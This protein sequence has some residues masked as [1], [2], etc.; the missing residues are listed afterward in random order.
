MPLERIQKLE[1]A[2]A[3][4]GKI[5]I[6]NQYTAGIAGEKFLRT[7][8][9]K[10]MLLAARCPE[11]EIVY[12]PAPLYCE[13]C[14]RPLQEEKELAPRGELLTF[15]I[16]HRD[17]DGQ[18]LAE[19]Q[20]LGFIKIAGSDGGLLHYLGEIKAEEIKIGMA[21]QAVLLPKEERQGS[22]L[23]IRY[24]RPIPNQTRD[25]GSA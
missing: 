17:L 4:Q 24:F 15:T 18:S 9:D 11:D 8:Q 12:L 2:R 3:W 13:R 5:P 10:G 23:D 21:M 20:V 7:L 1:E 25:K 19:P 16:L 6:E 22:I 14:F